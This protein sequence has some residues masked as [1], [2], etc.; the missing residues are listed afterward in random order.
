MATEFQKPPRTPSQLT[1]VQAS[2]QAARQASND[3]ADGKAKI[4][5]RR[6][7]SMLL[8]EVVSITYSGSRKKAAAK[9]RKA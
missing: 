1:P 2:L 7:S 6:I 3:G 9:S 8:N 5:P 4:W